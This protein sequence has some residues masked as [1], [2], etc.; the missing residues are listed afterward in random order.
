MT[1][2]IP[3][4]EALEELS[5]WH[6][7]IA[8]HADEG[9]QAQ[10]TDAV[11][12]AVELVNAMAAAPKP[13]ADAVA[14]ARATL[15]LVELVQPLTTDEARPWWDKLAEVHRQVVQEYAAA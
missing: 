13:A 9:A 5:D 1:R 7:A 4:P 6:R 8:R 3:F 14:L 15:R 11:T 10:L 2:T 12:N